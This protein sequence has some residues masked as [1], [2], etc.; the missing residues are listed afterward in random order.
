MSWKKD[1]W[2]VVK[3][4]LTEKELDDIYKK[5]KDEVD[6]YPKD[7]DIDEQCPLSPSFYNSK[8]MEKL[9]IDSLPNISKHIELDLFKTYS[10]WR[11]YKY[12]ET[13]L[14][15]TD[16]KACE[17]SGTIFIGGDPWDICIRSY[18]GTEHNVSQEPGDALIYRGC[19]LVHWRDEFKGNDH[20][21]IFIHYVD[22][23]GL[24]SALKNDKK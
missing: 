12:G 4:F 7:A 17:I 9:L 8:Y 1:G 6:K 24:N 22:Q 2:V 16:R 3:N 5:C 14:S 21:Q 13:L 20:A 11:W 18:D 15:H 10:F 23:H 19:D